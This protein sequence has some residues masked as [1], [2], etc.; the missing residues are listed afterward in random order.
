MEQIL[1]DNVILFH[2]NPF[3]P[4]M[5]LDRKRLVFVGKQLP[6]T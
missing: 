6:L 2:L 1:A 3:L 5:R 4:L